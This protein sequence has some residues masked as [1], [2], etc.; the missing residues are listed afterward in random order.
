[1]AR[2]RAAPARRSSVCCANDGDEEAAGDGLPL[3]Q[4]DRS[5]MTRRSDLTQLGTCD[6]WRDSRRAS[7]APAQNTVQRGDGDPERFGSLAT[8]AAVQRKHGLDMFAFVDAQRS[9]D[10]GG[11]R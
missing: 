6:P 9:S 11:W 1:M 2:S 7:G 4:S 10:H 5:V 3:G 8:L